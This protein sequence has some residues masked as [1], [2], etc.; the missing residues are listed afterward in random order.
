[1]AV[2]HEPR[3]HL[4]ELAPHRAALRL[5]A[6]E[7]SD[8][9]PKLTVLPVPKPMP[10]VANEN[11]VALLDEMLG[12]ARAGDVTDVALVILSEGGDKLQRRWVAGSNRATLLGAVT[13][14]GRDIETD[15]LGV[16]EV[17]AGR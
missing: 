2:A 16:V 6:A 12:R 1:M 14:L 4:H 9:L 10:L 17:I 3:R 15:I 13:L 11:I 8:D 5:Q 7:V